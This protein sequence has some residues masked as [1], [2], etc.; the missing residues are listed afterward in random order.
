[1]TK[2]IP[3]YKSQDYLDTLEETKE[4]IRQYEDTL[5]AQAVS[6]CCCSCWSDWHDT[7]KVGEEVEFDMEML[8]DTGD[9]NVVALVEMMEKLNDL[10]RELA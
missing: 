5:F 6:L 1:M 8:R 9:E 7:I 2:I 10:R 4:I 3:L